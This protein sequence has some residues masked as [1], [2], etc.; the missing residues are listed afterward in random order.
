MNQVLRHDREAI[1]KC[2]HLRGYKGSVRQPLVAERDAGPASSKTSGRTECLHPE[3][4][5]RQ[6]GT[7]TG[8]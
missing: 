4:F 6:D 1:I 5:L 2:L 8:A 7:S 3:L